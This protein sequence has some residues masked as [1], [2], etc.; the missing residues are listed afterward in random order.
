MSA[1]SKDTQKRKRSPEGK[2]GEDPGPE[3]DRLR[4]GFFP[5]RGKRLPVAYSLTGRNPSYFNEVDNN[6]QYQLQ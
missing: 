4:V 3:G 6:W 5:A 2:T 1:E